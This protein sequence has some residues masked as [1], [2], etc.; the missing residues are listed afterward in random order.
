M[1]QHRRSAAST[2]RSEAA[3]LIDRHVV[4]R[5]SPMPGVPAEPVRAAV[6]VG[7]ATATLT[8]PR[9]ASRSG[10]SSVAKGKSSEIVPVAG[11]TPDS[12]VLVTLQAARP[13]VYVQCAVPGH[14][15]FT[16]HLSKKA[17]R[18]TKFAWIVLN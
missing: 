1:A 16:V 14:G 10:A 18:A 4:L 11:M 8:A 2:R 9:E 3:A 17:P 5:R 12:L 13:G 6:P 15:G 7:A